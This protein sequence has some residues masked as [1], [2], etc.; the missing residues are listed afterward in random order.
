[1]D[2]GTSLAIDAAVAVSFFLGPLAALA[3][4]GA[5]GAQAALKYKRTVILGEVTMEYIR[6]NCTWGGEDRAVVIRRCKECAMAHYMKLLK[7][8][9]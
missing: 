5:L 8:N 1:V 3:A 7:L 4:V 6:H 2:F 9:E